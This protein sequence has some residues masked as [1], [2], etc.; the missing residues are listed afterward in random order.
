MFFFGSFFVSIPSRN[1]CR[2]HTSTFVSGREGSEAERPKSERNISS[3]TRRTWGTTPPKT[4]GWIPQIAMFKGSRYLFQ[5]P[6]FWVSMLV[7][8]EL[9]SESIDG[10]WTNP[11]EK[12]I[13]LGSLPQEFWVK[14]QNVWNH[15]GI[16]LQGT[17]TYGLKSG[18]IKGIFSLLV[19]QFFLEWIWLSF[20]ATNG[21]D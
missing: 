15:L 14:I 17:I 10:G 19:I 3:L 13:Q 5:G 4:N 20:E 21:W 6:S 12:Y 9:L 11:F 1:G 2:L 8:G 7:F 16:T 18:Y